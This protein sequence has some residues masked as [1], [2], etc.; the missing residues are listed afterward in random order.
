MKQNFIYMLIIVLFG[1]IFYNFWLTEW[2]YLV[3]TPMPENY[4]AVKTG[5]KITLD[6]TFFATNK[7]LFLHF[8]SPECPCS[9][10]N[11]DHFKNLVEKN[12]KNVNF[13]AILFA[14]DTLGVRQDFY[15]QYKVSIPLL[16]KNGTAL[17]ES[18]GVYSTP[19]AVILKADFTLFYRGNYN[20]SRYCS[21]KQTNFAEMALQALLANKTLPNFG[22]QATRAYGCELPEGYFSLKK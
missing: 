15:K 3:P 13:Y 4:Q 12:K 2:K 7:P 6:S 10:Y 17:A 21:D 19:Q 1:A 9:K 16:V 14:E 22:E 5:K 18:C 8:F 20:K 11:I